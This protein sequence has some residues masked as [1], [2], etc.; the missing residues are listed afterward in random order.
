MCTRFGSSTRVEICRH[1]D[2]GITLPGARTGRRSF[3]T[4]RLSS[5][6]K[7]MMC[8]VAVRQCPAAVHKDVANCN[9]KEIGRLGKMSNSATHIVAS[10]A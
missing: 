4:N 6:K 7:L 2:S 10:L 9:K 5:E 8:W 3:Q 1:P